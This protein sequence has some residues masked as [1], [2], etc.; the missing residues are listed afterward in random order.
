ME[1]KKSP[2]ANLENKKILF[3]EIGLVIALLLTVMAFE[4]RTYDKKISFVADVLPVD[5][6]EI[7]PVTIPELPLPEPIKAP[8]V[9]D[10]I[11]IVDN[12]IDIP[13]I[14]ITEEDNDK[15]SVKIR[16]YPPPPVI[17]E[18]IDD[19]DIPAP[20]V[21]EKPKFMGGDENEFTKWVFKNMVYPEVAI[22]NNIQGR[23][24]CSF[25]IAKDGNVVDVKILR[26]VDPLLDKEAIRVISMSPKW[27]PGKQH[28][29][30]VRVKY[31]FPVI[32]QLK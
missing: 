4:W 13:G 31:T 1:T 15:W 3:R 24:I 5:I 12:I 16:D 14:T 20:V 2:K 6:D 17:D 29:K 32:F 10:V 8:E 18:P 22:Q 7:V 11:T 30:P 27:A 21:E 23:V 19:G 28:G 26:G 25:V 9:T